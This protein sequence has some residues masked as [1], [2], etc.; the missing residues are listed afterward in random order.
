MCFLAKLAVRANK[1]A[2]P[3]TIA[4]PGLEHVYFDTSSSHPQISHDNFLSQ[5]TMSLGGG[6]LPVAWTDV[7]FVFLVIAT[8]LGFLRQT[9]Q[10][11]DVAEQRRIRVEK[12]QKYQK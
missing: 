2:F 1:G 12:I 4:S 7:L 11:S 9:F 6:A 5:S 3:I 10:S 8:V